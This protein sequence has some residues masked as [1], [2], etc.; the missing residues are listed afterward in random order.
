M[1]G[2][3]APAAAAAK[4]T[5]TQGM[6]VPVPA[7]EKA[8]RIG[9]I[10]VVLKVAGNGTAIRVPKMDTGI[11]ICLLAFHGKGG[12]YKDCDS[13]ATGLGALNDRESNRLCKFIDKSLAVISNPA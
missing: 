8:S 2:V 12:C 10:N 1:D 11:K 7:F 9:K 5:P 4:N 3:T 6:R 13:R